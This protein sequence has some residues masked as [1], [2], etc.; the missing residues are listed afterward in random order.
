MKVL[1]CALV[2][3]LVCSVTV[4]SLR[5]FTCQGDNCKV[6]TE[7]PASANYCK[8]A[9]SV[10]FLSRTCEEFCTPEVNVHCCSED[11]CG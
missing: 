1:A 7:C 4:H 8:T 11:L 6:E 9:A 10:D 3:M 5:C 2:V